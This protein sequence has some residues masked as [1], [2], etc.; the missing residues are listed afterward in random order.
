MKTYT[1]ILNEEQVKVLRAALLESRDKRGSSTR[2]AALID[3][4]TTEGEYPLQEEGIN[5]LDCGM[6]QEENA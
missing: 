4:L 3:M 1:I 6:D 5:D 2:E